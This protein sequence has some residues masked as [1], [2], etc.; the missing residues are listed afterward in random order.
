M[1][2]TRPV[3]F[4]VERRS[5]DDVLLNLS[6]CVFSFA[7]MFFVGLYHAKISANVNLTVLSELLVSTDRVLE[8]LRMYIVVSNHVIPLG[9]NFL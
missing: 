2:N 5:K 9:A 6:A 4:R 1:P 7:L 8:T 3:L